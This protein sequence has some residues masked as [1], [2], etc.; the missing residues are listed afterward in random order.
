VKRLVHT[1][2]SG[3]GSLRPLLT[4]K[5]F[6][7]STQEGR[8]K[9]RMRRALLTSA[10]SVI[11]RVISLA[12]PLITVPLALGYL[13]H[14][15]YGLWMTVIAIFGMFTFA[16]L[17]LGNGLITEISQAE[18][19]DDKQESRRCIA[20]A[21][22]ALCGI[23]LVLLLLF[24]ILFPFIPWSR[25]VNATSPLLIRESGAV[26]TVCFLVFLLN[27]PLGI[28]QRA[29]SGFQQGFQSNLWQCIGS[30]INVPVVLIAVKTHASLPVLILG[31]AAVQPLVSLFNG[32]AFFG[33][34]CPHLRPRLQ[35]FH[36]ATARRL[37][38]TGF[39]FFLV[40]ILTALGIYSDNVV[41]AQIVGLDTVPLYAIPASMAG[42]LGAVA[43]MLYTPFW[44]ANGEALARGDIAW[45][46]RNTTRILKLNLLITGSAGLA[47]VIAGPIFLHW[48][49]APDFSP[50][51]FLLAGM[52]SWAL[53]ISAAGPFFMVL[54][55]ANAVRVQ[56]GMFGLFS[57]VAITLKIILA[58]RIGIAGV[59]WAS[60]VPYALLVL[61]ALVWAMRGVMRRADNALQEQR[62]RSDLPLPP[63]KVATAGS[64]C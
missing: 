45:V 44:A 10:S 35:D 30:V 37:F 26:V 39:W 59:V 4:R 32:C 41:V 34:Q 13:G 16:D 28:V 38:G 40:S 9:E 48:W 55:G 25:L 15:R 20:S 63:A 58:R 56:V 42:Y 19:R 54:N 50:G 3:I 22:F 11:V 46:R 6:N 60:V 64:Q 43:S 52:A 49:I 61:P 17:G 27:L 51:R 5:P 7:T 24:V 53:L 29:Q 1:L 57:V 47:F 21:F 33:F 23:S 62:T 14:E 31:V 18:G 8:S 12:S 36:W 2:Q